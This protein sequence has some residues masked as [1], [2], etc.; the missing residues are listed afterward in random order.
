MKAKLKELMPN[1]FK[2]YINKGA[3]TQNRLDIMKESIEHGTLPE[4]FTARKNNGV[5]E[6]TSGHHRHH[7]LMEKKGKEYEVDI[8]LVDF[9]DEQMLIDNICK[10]ASK[11]IILSWAVPGQYSASGHVNNQT[12]EYIIKQFFERKFIFN[13]RM[14]RTLRQYRFYKWFE[15]TLMVFY[16]KEEAK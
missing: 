16:K 14:T 1:P 12:N 9:N 7:A 13:K 4:H 3:L 6:L 11:D 15:N 8:T 5:L 2:K 10:F